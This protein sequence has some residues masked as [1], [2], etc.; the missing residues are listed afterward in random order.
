M[1]IFS[2]KSSKEFWDAVNRSV[3]R[4]TLY[5]YGCKAQEL[6]AALKAIWP[7]IKED[8]PKG[9]GKDHGTCAT[10]KYVEA[11]NMLEQALKGVD[12]VK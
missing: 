6:E 7:F 12:A 5:H 2:G 3:D 8:F 10:D 1:S 4:N 9:T 11:A